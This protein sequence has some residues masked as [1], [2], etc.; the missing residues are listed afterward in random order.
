M[1]TYRFFLMTV[2]VFTCVIGSEA[3]VAAAEEAPSMSGN[4]VSTMDPGIPLDQLELLLNHR[5]RC[6]AADTEGKG[7]TDQRC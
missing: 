6:L 3:P 2:F 1:N 5:S 4:A 7:Q